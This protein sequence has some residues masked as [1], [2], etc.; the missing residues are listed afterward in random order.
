[1]SL[2]TKTPKSYSQ[3]FKRNTLM[4]HLK[5]KS[6]ALYFAGEGLKNATDIKTHYY[7]NGKLINSILQKKQFR[8]I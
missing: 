2:L 6:L 1:M 5:F 4:L 8:G 3:L 7:L